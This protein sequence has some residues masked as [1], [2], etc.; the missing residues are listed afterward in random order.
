[1]LETFLQDLRIGFR[2]LTKEK[3]FCTLAVSV[4]ALGIS[5]VTTQFAVVNG[6]L[7]HAFDFPGA[8]RLVDVH[9]VDPE[10]FT[11]NN[12]RSQMLMQD[13]TDIRENQQ[14]FEYF[15]GYLNGSTINVTYQG[16]PRRFTGG[17]VA[18]DFFDAIGVFPVMGREFLPEDN[19]PGVTKAVLLSDSLWQSEFG[20][21]PN[22]IGES[23]IVNGTAAEVV[24]I[25]PPDFNFPQN[26][27]LW[28]PIHSEFPTRPRLEVNP[29]FAAILGKLKPGV[30]MDQ[31]QAEITSF[32]Q[33]FAETYPTTNNQFSQGYVRPLIASF[34][35]PFITGLM[36][37][38]LAI[39]VGVLLIACVNVMNMQ[40]AR[41]TLR[42]KE[43]AIR[44]SLGA[45]RGRLVRQMLTESL[46]LAAIGA[47][48]GIS[49]SMWSVDFLDAAVHNSSNPIPSWMRFEID[50][51]VMIGVV[52]IT[53]LA[54]LM[55]GLI[56]ALISS[57]A[58]AVEVLKEGGRGNTSRSAMILSRGLVVF[59]ILMTSILLIATMLWV[60]TVGNLQ[61]I[62]FGFETEGVI[63]G[64]MGL[65]QGAY[66][67]TTERTGFYEK[68]LRE[69]RASAQFKSVSLTNRFRM[70]FSGNGP[71]EIEGREYNSLADRRITNF[72]S[73]SSGHFATLGLKIIE[74]RDFTENDSDQREPVA[75][76]NAAF[77]REQ[78]GKESPIGKR[79]RT[80]N[81]N[82]TNPG[83]WR[84][85][86]GVVPTMRMQGPFNN[87]V[88]EAGFYLPFFGTPFGPAAEEPQAPQFGTIVARPLGDQP[89]A[90]LATQLQALVNRV[91]PNLPMYFVETPGASIAALM[92]QNDLIGNTFLVFG[93]VALLLAAVGLYG[94]MS[95]AVNQR[96]QEFGVRMALGA[97]NQSIMRM[98]L[99]QAA[100]QLILGLV[101][102]LGIA[103]GISL[104]FNEGL[105]NT[106]V[107]ISPRDP[108]T[109][110]GV[111]LMLTLVAAIATFV[112]ARR[113]TRVDP[114]IALRAE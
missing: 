40:F 56:P 31:A 11:P 17:Y 99:N 45:T 71:V 112:P 52:V 63:A 69:L 104:I 100:K 102:G 43:L 108:M 107:D 73:I 38:M 76:V 88:K 15:A 47:V 103:V 81:G 101:L 23:L 62:D 111:A 68:L 86:V 53:T 33:K 4:L 97:D 8:D 75:I 114:M 65:M 70:V 20:G 36:L 29:G 34:T 85:I 3:G 1:M 110:L 106:L 41:A 89:A 13:Y 72:E 109:Y 6:V 79:L 94:I 74:G 83:M 55:S 59:Q 49:I 16:Q 87:Q 64:R 46:L 48:V 54:A 51:T 39:C 57:R 32:A 21:D 28:L 9:I 84:R 14:S 37:V 113:A 30:S 10:N 5:G 61:R 12:F 66:P 42:A 60:Q 19:Q 50:V 91:D 25:M 95:F 96:T 2:I 18:D 77:A 90:G 58:N 22:V 7:L 92:S 78:F 35:G 98:V 93:S 80:I 26:E 105:S 67:S 82:G 44:S 24:G 27:Q